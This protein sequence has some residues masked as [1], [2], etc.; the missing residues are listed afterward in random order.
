MAGLWLLVSCTKKQLSGDNSLFGY[1]Y[2]PVE[3]GRYTVYEVD[4]TVY[5]DLPKDTVEYKYRIK[6]RFAEKFTD[7]EGREA[8]RLE[9]F[10]KKYNPAVPYDSM[11][12]TIKEVWWLN[13]N[14]SSVQVVQGNVRYTKLIFPVEENANWNGNAYNSNPA[15][16][17]AYDYIERSET[18][19]ATRFEKVLLVK[20]HFSSTAIAY[21][22]YTEK[23]A[24]GSGLVSREI[25]D[26]VSSK[27]VTSKPVLQRIE[28]GVVYKQ[29]YLGSGYE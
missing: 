16:Q 3:I 23:Y 12:W 8:I 17:Y 5:T 21:Q 1:E 7:N 15:W 13:V 29:T 25:T 19:R 4:S 14:K 18:I 24:K 26:V 22:S 27:S 6:E 9:R 2:Y 10:I 11:P 28:S 20:Q